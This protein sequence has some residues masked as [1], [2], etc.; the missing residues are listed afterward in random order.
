SHIT[1]GVTPICTS[2]ILNITLTAESPC[3]LPLP[4]VQDNSSGA[5]LKRR[6]LSL[7]WTQEQT[8]KN[9]DILKDSY[10]KWEWNKGVPDIKKR[11]A[12]CKFLGYNYWD[13]GTG[14]LANRVLLYRIERGLH[15]TELARELG[16]SDSSIERVEKEF[17]FVSEYLLIRI[18]RYLK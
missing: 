13:D 10:Q 5:E 16:V 7:E 12:V 1:N 18:K 8:A 6:R 4:P 3:Y 9:F 15:R 2:P 11:K 14:S 17:K